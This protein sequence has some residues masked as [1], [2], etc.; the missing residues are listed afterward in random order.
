[1][2]A[3]ALA[4]TAEHLAMFPVDTVKTRMQLMGLG[5]S[6]QPLAPRSLLLAAHAQG[7]LSQLWRGWSAIGLGAGPA[8]AVHFA[9]YEAVKRRLGGSQVGHSPIAT[10]AGGACATIAG[11]AVMVPHETIKSRLQRSDSPYRN[12]ADCVRKTYSI[13][14]IGAFFRSYKATLLMNIPFTAVHFA[15]YESSKIALRQLASVHLS[16]EGPLVQ[17]V[18]GATSGGFAA[19]FTTPLDVAKTRLQTTHLYSSTNIWQTLARIWTEEGPSALLRGLRP[20]VLFHVPAS[21]ICWVTYETGK[22]I[23]Q[24]LRDRSLPVN[25]SLT[26]DSV[27]EADAHVATSSST[28]G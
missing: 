6:A 23:C 21:I 11:D 15:S 9:T 2:A 18:A 13:E 26:S 27:A 24:S 12:F 25:S 7:G 22:S 3:G 10:A 5:S 1:M 28:D 8:H 20:R 4:G 14:G 17:G 19:A 16:D